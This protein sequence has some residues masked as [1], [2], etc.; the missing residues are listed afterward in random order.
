MAKCRNGGSLRDVCTLFAHGTFVSLTDAE[1]IE[2]FGN[3][4][5]DSAEPAFAALVARHGP[6]VLRVCRD[7]LRDGHAA[8]DSFQA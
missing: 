3:G 4:D 1:L 7:L 5:A 6:M 8:E 2:R